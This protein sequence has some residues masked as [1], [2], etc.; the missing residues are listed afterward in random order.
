MDLAVFGVPGG[1]LVVGEGPFE[2]ATEPPAHGVAFYRNDFALSASEAWLIPAQVRE[3]P[4]GETLQPGGDEV[5]V[6]Y[7][8]SGRKWQRDPQSE[9]KY[10]LSAE[11][12]GFKVLSSSGDATGNQPVE[13]DIPYGETFSSDEDPPF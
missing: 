3:I 4:R 12:T 9:T 8:L 13:A 6:S 2:R 5:E 11:A 1:G 7:R 10:L